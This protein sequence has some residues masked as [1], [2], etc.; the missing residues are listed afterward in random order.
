MLQDSSQNL[1]TSLKKLKT[2]ALAPAWRSGYRI[3]LESIL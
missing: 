2:I 3:R 1:S